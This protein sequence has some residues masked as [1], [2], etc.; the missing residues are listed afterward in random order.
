MKVISMSAVEILPALLNHDKTQTIRPA[1]KTM[2]SGKGNIWVE[3]GQHP[4]EKDVI[5]ISL[6]KSIDI[7]TKSRFEVGDICQIMWKQ[8]TSPKDSWFCKICGKRVGRKDSVCELHGVVGLGD[9]SFPK[10]LG[11][12]KITEVFQIEMWKGNDV[13]LVSGYRLKDSEELAKRD[14]FKIYKEF[15]EFFAGKRYDWLDTPKKFWVIRWE[16]I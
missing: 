6:G 2:K 4:T 16:W 10:I 8:R 5:G 3:L 7:P 11:K 15:F 13:P 12:V 9:W 14:G 1:W